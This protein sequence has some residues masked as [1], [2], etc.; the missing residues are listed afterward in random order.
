MKQSTVIPQT[1]M[2]RV[3]NDV[4]M[5]IRD[6]NNVIANIQIHLSDPLEVEPKME[7]YM[8]TV[9]VFV[10]QTLA[11][12]V[13]AGNL[14]AANLTGF[15]KCIKAICAKALDIAFTETNDPLV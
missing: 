14:T 13:T 1:T 10:N 8:K 11:D 7:K 6:P 4:N 15:K 2:D 3:I 12:E 9:M 5:T